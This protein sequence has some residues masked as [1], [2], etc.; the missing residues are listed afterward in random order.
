MITI[1]EILKL[2]KDQANIDEN[3]TKDKY[4]QALAWDI[5]DETGRA[6]SYT[7]LKRLYEDNITVRAGYKPSD[8]TK[9]TLANY[10]GCVTWEKLEEL[11]E[12]SDQ[13]KWTPA[14]SGFL[15]DKVME[16]NMK[17]MNIHDI[18]V[19]CYFPQRVIEAEKIE[20]LASGASRFRVLNSLSCKLRH[21]DEFEATNFV[22]NS[23]FT[24]DNVLHNGKS[25]HKYTAADLHRIMNV[26]IKSAKDIAQKVKEA[27]DKD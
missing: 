12:L 3:L 22:R 14:K 2:V 7:T 17:R 9:L 20:Q 10:L 6:I 16:F 11:K 4:Y 19:V 13:G 23:T 5:E 27:I 1:D 21:D 18:I 26:T 25:Y 24:V 8:N 15:D